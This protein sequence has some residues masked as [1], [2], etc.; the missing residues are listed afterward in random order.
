MRRRRSSRAFS[1]LVA[2]L[3]VCLFT[4][5]GLRAGQIVRPSPAD[6]ASTWQSA[7]A[8]SYS[9]ART[10]AFPAAYRPAYDSGWRAG[11]AAADAAGL[12]AGRAAGRARAAARAVAARALAA[13]LAATPRTLKRGIRTEMCVP[14]A[15][16][17]CEVLGPHVTGRPCPAGSVAY[18]EGGEVCL[19]RILL[20]LARNDR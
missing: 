1:V 6:A 2:T 18:A 19:P 7:A 8:N 20:M 11:V 4:A 5:V 17:L 10:R 16:G 15:G 14:V 12:E 9:Q 3:M 13:V